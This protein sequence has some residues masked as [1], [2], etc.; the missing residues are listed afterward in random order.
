[1]RRE[2]VYFPDLEL[3]MDEKR[4]KEL[5]ESDAR[6]RDDK[7][8]CRAYFQDGMEAAEIAGV[9]R[10]PVSTVKGILYRYKKLIPDE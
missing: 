9:L 1:M 8:V 2:D 7:R 4:E 5:A 6:H 10:V 3:L